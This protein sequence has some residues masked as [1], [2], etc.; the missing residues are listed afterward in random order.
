V[1][2]AKRLLV[3]AS[4]AHGGLVAASLQVQDAARPGLTGRSSECP[5]YSPGDASGKSPDIKWAA[6]NAVPEHLEYGPRCT[7]LTNQVQRSFGD[8]ALKQR[9]GVRVLAA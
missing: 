2:R 3:Y 8:A 9:A 1:I 4:S 7:S 5:R 6:F